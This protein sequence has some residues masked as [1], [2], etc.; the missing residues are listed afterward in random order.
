MGGAQLS[1][2]SETNLV[3]TFID[4]DFIE[5]DDY[6]LGKSGKQ[7]YGDI[8]DVQTSYN[9]S[10]SMPNIV[11]TDSIRVYAKIIGHASSNGT[12]YTLALEE[13]H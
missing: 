1:S 3:T 7:W 11:N 8:Y 2:S 4:Y 12:S 9:Y 13:I 5:E 10:F 6:N